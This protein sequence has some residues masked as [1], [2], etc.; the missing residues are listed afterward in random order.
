MS[1]CRTLILPNRGSI[2]VRIP[3]VEA[4][5]SESAEAVKLVGELCPVGIDDL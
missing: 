4:D 2:G 3:V 1:Y 5:E